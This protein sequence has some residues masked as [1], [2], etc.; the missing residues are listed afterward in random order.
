MDQ[1]EEERAA[2]DRLMETEEDRDAFLA[3]D[4]GPQE[5]GTPGGGGGLGFLQPSATSRF[6]LRKR[7][8]RVPPGQGPGAGGGQVRRSTSDSHTCPAI[9]ALLLKSYLIAGP[10]G[11]GLRVGL[12]PRDGPGGARG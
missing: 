12:Q 8:R 4:A 9:I 2:L 5:L 1:E 11:F 10:A 3:E 7:K 6:T